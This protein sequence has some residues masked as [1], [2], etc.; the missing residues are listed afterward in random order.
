MNDITIMKTIPLFEGL[1]DHQM[2]NIARVGIRRTYRRDEIIFME[3]DDGNGFYIVEAGQIKIYKISSEGKEQILHFFG[4]GET[5]GEVAVFT[6]H[7]FP[8]Y[9]KANHNA[10]CLFIPRTDFIEIIRQDPTLAMNLLGVMSLRL[11]KF[12]RLIEDLSLKEVP[13]RLSAYLIYMSERSPD[14]AHLELEISKSQLAALLGTIPETLSRILTR[15]A[16]LNYLKSEGPGINIL[17][18][19]ALASIASGEMKLP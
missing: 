18:K 14:P 15:M 8:A 7:G 6:G 17:D 9:A 10:I 11:H 16:R 1:Q 13:G 2:E 5:F 4:P 12:T 19:E 3:G